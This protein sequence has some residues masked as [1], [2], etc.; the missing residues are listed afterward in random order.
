MDQ[1][2]SALRKAYQASPPDR[3][4]E[5]VTVPKDV[6]AF[7]SRCATISPLGTMVL[8]EEEGRRR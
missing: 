6:H 2:G 7:H 4:S 5:G 3:L 8:S 1:G